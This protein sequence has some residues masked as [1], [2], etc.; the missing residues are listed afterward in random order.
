MAVNVCRAGKD[1]VGQLLAGHFQAEN[2]GR[3][4]LLTCHV[5]G[6]V[7][8]KGG[9]AHTGAGCQNDQVGA[10][11]P[12]QHSVQIGK[13]RGDAGKLI[14]VSTAELLHGVDD[15]K[16]GFPDGLDA[17]LV[18][19]AADLVNFLFGAFQQQV[20]ILAGGGFV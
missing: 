10:S 2:D 11:Q 14:A 15:L 13:A 1:A 9:L 17:R 12:G 6:N 16:D 4:L 18:A 19:P 7:Q 20:R 8:R 5:G 3:H